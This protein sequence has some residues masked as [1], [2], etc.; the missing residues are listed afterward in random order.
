MLARVM[1]ST[2]IDAEP[3]KPS[4]VAV[5]IAVPGAELVTSAVALRLDAT[6]ATFGA[7][8]VQ[9]TAGPTRRL[10]AESR[11]T[12]RRRTPPPPATTVAAAGAIAAD[13]TGPPRGA[14]Q[15]SPS[16]WPLIRGAGGRA[17]N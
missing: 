16:R 15:G 8:L 2:V 13:P 12:A 14:D 6:V 9:V 7:A 17:H 1:V 5:M 4:A 11:S 10:P 3:L